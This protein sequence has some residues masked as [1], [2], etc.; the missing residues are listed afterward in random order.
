M[1]ILKG[2]YVVKKK[3]YS[4]LSFFHFVFA[5]QQLS[6][7]QGDCAFTGHGPHVPGM[8]GPKNKLPAP[9]VYFIKEFFP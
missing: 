6:V 9:F 3:F 8:G 7:M 2:I 5:F 1:I 4:Q